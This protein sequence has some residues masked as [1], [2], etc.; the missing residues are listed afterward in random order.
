MTNITVIGSI[1]NDFVAVT[2]ARPQIGETIEGQSFSIEFGG[3][4]ANQAVAVSRLGAQTN[5]IGCVGE[6][7]L[8][9]QLIDNLKNQN[10]NTQY[11]VQNETISSGSAQITIAD[12]ENSIIYVPGANNL[13]NSQLID[14]AKETLLNS[15]IVLIQN[16]IPQDTVEYIINYC[17]E[18]NVRVILNPAPARL[19]T[20]EIL[21]KVTY[22]TPNETEFEVMFEG[23]QMDEV[24]KQ[25]PN[26]II[27][28]LGTDGAAYHNGEELIVVPAY[29]VNQVVD[30]TGAGDTF[31][32]GF[33]V[34]M[35]QGLSVSNSIQLGSLA[36]SISIQKFGAQ[37]GM[38]TK[39]EVVRS[40]H[41]EKKWDFK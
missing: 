32:G 1:S 33:A 24:L 22:L 39:D 8:G 27:V 17:F 41:Y 20:E 9:Q 29:L 25:Y 28:T 14:Q 5:M 23:Q 36:A 37:G 4:G 13:V 38:P 35:A 40:E 11:V 21:D 26:K 7:V 3:K 15:D 12:G 6:G 16:E 30:T 31:N 34:G 19:I 10:I 2:T 18:N